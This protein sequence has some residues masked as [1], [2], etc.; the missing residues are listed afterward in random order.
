M[1]SSKY[2]KNRIEPKANFY[3]IQYYIDRLLK[4]VGIKNYCNK[5]EIIFV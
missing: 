1:Y 5:K 3:G 2:K 4:A